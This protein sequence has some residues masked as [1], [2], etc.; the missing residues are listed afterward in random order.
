[1]QRH[2]TKIALITLIA[3]VL[4][5]MLA[6][7]APTKP[8]PTHIGLFTKPLPPAPTGWRQDVH[9]VYAKWL[10]YY[11][12]AKNADKRDMFMSVHYSQNGWIPGNRKSKYFED[13]TFAVAGKRRLAELDKMANYKPAYQRDAKTPYFTSNSTIGTWKM[14]TYVRRFIAR[15]RN[16][17]SMVQVVL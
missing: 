3:L 14:R 12:R 4:L 2:I 1:M 10:S 15:G 9:S 6:T 16:S 7:A 5:P 17:T 13:M 8:K 11:W